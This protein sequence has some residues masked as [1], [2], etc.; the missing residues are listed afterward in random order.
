[1]Q[2]D[3]E[4]LAR[5][6]YVF[7][8]LGMDDRTYT[9]LSVRTPGGESYYIYPLGLLF[10]EVTPE[11]LIK[12]DFEGRILEGVE[13]TFNTTGYT[14]HS[15]VYKARPDINAIF[16]LHTLATT[17]VSAMRPGLLPLSQFAFPFYNRLSFYEYDALTLSPET[18]GRDLAKAL[19][20]K[21]KAML[22]R[23][24]GAMTCGAT[25][26]EAFFYMMFLENAC[27]V[28]VAALPA[29]IENLIIPPA[30]VIEQAVQ[31]MTAFEAGKIGK[32]DF[33]AACRVTDFP[34]HR[35]NERERPILKPI[36][37]I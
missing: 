7:A 10:E 20:P 32:R 31:D 3:K 18:Q 4:T 13:Q 34:W 11:K 5:C 9:H 6:Y 2:G 28:Q 25:L 33:E 12:V 36:A 27:Q 1:M 14:M 19:G 29:G 22:L 30:S 21:N 26:E 37:S 8:Q 17:A 24:H 35:H 16:H 15:S 23:N